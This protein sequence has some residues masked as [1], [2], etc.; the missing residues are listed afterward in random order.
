LKSKIK[1]EAEQMAE[2]R[3]KDKHKQKLTNARLVM[4]IDKGT[5]SF[6]LKK[7]LE[8]NVKNQLSIVKDG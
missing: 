5:S 8:K 7:I 2:L 4:K 1:S 3:K 6:N